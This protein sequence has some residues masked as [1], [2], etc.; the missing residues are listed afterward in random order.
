MAPLHAD[1]ALHRRLQDRQGGQRLV[2][3]HHQQLQP[4]S[5][6]PPLTLV[7]AEAEQV[8]EIGDIE[9]ENV[10]TSGVFVD[11]VV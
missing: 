11:Y 9:P 1:V 10:R 5:W 6:P 2:Q 3:G 7:I 8:V 4:A